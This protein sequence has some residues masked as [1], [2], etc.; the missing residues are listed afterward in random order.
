MCIGKKNVERV[1]GKKSIIVVTD[2][3]KLL[4]HMRNIVTSPVLVQ[5][6]LE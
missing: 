5:G 6:L 2:P 1:L 3:I 4:W